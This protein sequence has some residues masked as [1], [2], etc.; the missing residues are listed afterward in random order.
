ME[1]SFTLWSVKS[2]LEKIPF[3]LPATGDAIHLDFS[4]LAVPYYVKDKI[5]ASIFYMD[6]SFHA[7]AMCCIRVRNDVVT[8]IIIMKRKYEDSLR[9]WLETHDPQ[10]LAD[11]CRR[12]E[13]YCHEIAHLI[14]II[15]AYPSDRSSRARD[16][17]VLKLRNKFIVSFN[18][19]QN[20][21][22]FP[23]ISV[24][25]PGE[26]PSSFDKDHFRYEEDS[27]NYFKLFQELM[28]SYDRI[29]DALTRIIEKY[30]KTHNTF[31]ITYNDVAEETCAAKSFFDLFPEKRTELQEVLTE[32]L[33][34]SPER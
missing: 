9:L 15:R 13:L 26:A 21:R 18:N 20:F 16:D 34:K 14:S 30:R 27:L 24:Q 22:A 31:P 12:R 6:D 19:V 3:D 1:V 2:I 17:F 5:K 33:S 10:Y 28:L 25:N 32:M 4:Q 23:L 11:C 7:D 8:V 29:V